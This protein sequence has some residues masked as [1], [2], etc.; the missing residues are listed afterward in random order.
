MGRSAYGGSALLRGLAALP[1]LPVMPDMAPL[2]IVQLD[3]LADT[4][5][6]CLRP[7]APARMTLDV[8]GPERLSFAE[9]V[10]HYRRWL[11]WPEAPHWRVPRWLA[12]GLF[13]LGDAAGQL[14]W[15]TPVRSTARQEMARG[16]VGDPAD[17]MRLTGITPRPLAAAL[18]AEPAS[19]QERWFAGLYLLK[20]VLF[21]VLALFWI[22]TGVISLG[23][24]YGTGIALMQAGGAGVLSGPSVVGGAVA[25]IVIGLAIAIRRT[26]RLGLYAAMAITIFYLA[27]GT[28]LLPQLWLDPLGALLK[29]LP[30]LVL[31][32]VALAMLEDR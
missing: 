27:A 7:G 8:A 2:Q 15:R 31:H 26:T 3:E 13:R 19:V 23:P 12:G 32:L 6:V 20:P 14:G 16:A 10:G 9:A 21:A 5:L 4:V 30:I 29:G 11:G 22:A 24:G 1:L 25:D 18:A 28:V 17:W